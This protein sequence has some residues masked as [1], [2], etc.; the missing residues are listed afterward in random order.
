MDSRD[1]H[2]R[3][4]ENASSDS[5]QIGQGIEAFDSADHRHSDDEL[6][7]ETRRRHDDRGENHLS[8]ATAR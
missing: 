6:F 3:R 4:G 2:G 5:L 8:A 7:R 1:H